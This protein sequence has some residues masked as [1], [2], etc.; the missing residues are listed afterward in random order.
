MGQRVT[1]TKFFF[2]SAPLLSAA[3][4]MNTACSYRVSTTK[5]IAQ[6]QEGQETSGQWGATRSRSLN[7]PTQRSKAIPIR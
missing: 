6:D 5:R 4:D 3:T 2:S 1:K 7:R